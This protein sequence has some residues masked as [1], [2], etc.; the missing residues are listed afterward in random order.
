MVNVHDTSGLKCI[1]DITKGLHI[2]YSEHNAKES[3]QTTDMQRDREWNLQASQNFIYPNH[4]VKDTSWITRFWVPKQWI[5][6]LGNKKRQQT[7]QNEKVKEPTQNAAEKTL[8][9]KAASAGV[10][11]STQ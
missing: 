4:I 7:Q 5:R 8:W 11:T 1:P 3:C 6:G 2:I 10:W 9:L